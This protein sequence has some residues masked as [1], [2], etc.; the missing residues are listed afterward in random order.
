MGRGQHG[1]RL[2]NQGLFNVANQLQ[3]HI[4]TRATGRLGRLALGLA[5]VWFVVHTA[6]YAA[7]MCRLDATLYKHLE[8]AMKHFFGWQAAGFFIAAI[9]VATRR[10]AATSRVLTVYLLGSTVVLL[11]FSRDIAMV[12]QLAVV[13]LW[14]VCAVEGM[15]LAIFKA[16]GERYGT[17]GVAAAT[18]YA[19]FVLLGFLLGVLHAITPTNVALLAIAAAL[20][21]AVCWLRRI[22]VTFRTRI[23]CKERATSSSQHG[24]QWSVIAFCLIEVIWVVMAMEF[25]RAGTSEV[26]SD[27]VRVH[28]PY[29]LQVVADHG[30]SHQYACW[31]RLQPMAV[32]AYSAM[33]ISVGSVAVAKL[34]SWLALAALGL[35]VVE[36]AWRR[37]GSRDVGLFAGAAVMSCPV[38]AG[39]SGSLYVD[40][41]ITLLCTAGFI[42][43]FRALRPPCLRGLLFSAA[44]M[45]AMV[46]VKYTGLVF[47]AVWSVF[48]AV[49]LLRRRG[50]RIAATWSAAAGAMLAATAAPWFV[51]VYLG[52]GNPFY[53]Y[54][55]CWFPSPYWVDGFTLQKQVFEMLFKLSP[56]IGGVTSFP[57]TAT[58]NSNQYVEGWN[59]I[60]GFWGLALAPCC[61]L[62]WLLRRKQVKQGDAGLA[63]Y[64]DMVIVGVAMVAG[65]VTYTPYIRY[66]I[67]AYP[68]LVVSCVLAAG[69]LLGTI[70]WRPEHRW[71]PVLAGTV[72]SSALLLPVPLWCVNMPWDAYARRI[73]SEQYLA[74]R[75]PEYEPA[76][77]FNKIIEPNDGVL[78]T[79]CTGVYL[80]GGRPYEF[81]FWWDKILHISDC[82]SFVEFCRRN[83]IHYWVVNHASMMSRSA[84]GHMDIATEYWSDKRIVFA[85]GTIAVYDVTSRPVEAAARLEWPTSLD[86]SAKRSSVADMPKDWVNLS[87]ESASPA[88]SGIS[89]MGQARIGHRI[90]A[91]CPGG[92]CSLKFDLCSSED[93][94]PIAEVTWYDARGKVVGHLD[95]GIPGN[96]D[97]VVR[98]Y[99]PVPPDAASGW[100]DLR[101]WNRKP[102]ELKRATAT[103]RE[104]KNESAVARR[105]KPCDETGGRQ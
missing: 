53:P 40:H 88:K 36:E 67:P 26:R 55:N 58:Y 80:I 21:G 34:F 85:L 42:V 78:C 14:T 100:V 38:L 35:L 56:G 50:W 41:V 20:P 62:A 27:S 82:N 66:W 105:D 73:T 74:Q 84:G 24:G 33:M 97:F 39:L 96:S 18:V 83:R 11:A 71:G 101:E 48:L 1:R 91:K 8:H 54:L 92:I 6:I 5:A 94:T 77:D 60:L 25:V 99:A 98:F 46:Q 29:M 31:H 23:D 45:G 49:D 16:V 43:L 4:S 89:L 2:L 102:F 52:T 63:A 10:P 61:L 90:E 87:D 19:V 59:G 104:L 17:Y 70:H 69:S 64:W 28:L 86:K 30:L 3:N 13:L 7:A 68:L 72:L 81:A 95:G 79:G 15:R 37:G 57:W 75:F 47:A 103:F 51:Y 22:A 9:V 93:V 76:K 65:I 12:G 44:I 32:Q